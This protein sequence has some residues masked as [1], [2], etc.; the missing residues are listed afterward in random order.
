MRV[1][2]RQAIAA[3][4]LVLGGTIGGYATWFRDGGDD[5]VPITSGPVRVVRPGVE[6]QKIVFGP[7]FAL[8]ASFSEVAV[9]A[10]PGQDVD[11]PSADVTVVGTY[12]LFGDRLEP[13]RTRGDVEIYED[14]FDLD[15]LHIRTSYLVAPWGQLG[16]VSRAADATVL[17]A[18]VDELAATERDVTEAGELVATR[19]G[20][21]VGFVG[22]PPTWDG[23]VRY[24]D[25]ALALFG[26][27]SRMASIQAAATATLRPDGE[28]TTT[29][30]LTSTFAGGD[31]MRVQPGVMGTMD[32]LDLTVDLDEWHRQLD[33]LLDG[34]V[35]TLSMSGAGV[36]PGAWY[37][38]AEAP[39]CLDGS[40]A[41]E[42][43]EVVP[44]TD[45]AAIHLRLSRDARDAL[46]TDGALI[47]GLGA[48]VQLWGDHRTGRVEIRTL[49]PHAK[50][51]SSQ[52]RCGLG[53]TWVAAA[54][55]I[56]S[57]LSNRLI[58][59]RQHRDG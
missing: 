6:A 14:E 23:N 20:G 9:I 58:A 11:D 54:A 32:A 40:D 5:D 24:D 53:D 47:V 13:D 37:E 1:A 4:A 28:G 59:V 34:S 29:G 22:A 49:P 51:K 25:G 56:C 50:P 30:F 43:A 12:Q 46:G 17:A 10:P 15:G 39:V 18:V 44:V 26:P 33:V 41:I 35:P 36:F 42:D 57:G 48:H 31:Q 55:R 19:L 21:E 2:R 45:G 8:L 27:W 38:C 52:M 7:Q 16:V 3:V